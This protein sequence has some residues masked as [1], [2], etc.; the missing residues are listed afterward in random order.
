MPTSTPSPSR[1]DFLRTTAGGTILSLSA[2][3]YKAVFAAD[4]P[5]SERVRL[6][7]IGVGGQGNADLGSCLAINLP[8]LPL[9]PM[10]TRNIKLRRQKRSKPKRAKRRLRRR[11]T[12]SCLTP[13]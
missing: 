4:A 12:G 5:P 2:L 13:R 1:R 10:S 11:I 8:L 9:F 7:F 3:S 6:G